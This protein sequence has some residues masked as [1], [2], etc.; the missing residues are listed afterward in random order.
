MTKIQEFVYDPTSGPKLNFQIG[1]YSLKKALSKLV[2][3]VY[4]NTGVF[5]EYQRNVADT[6][7]KKAKLFKQSNFLKGFSGKK[8]DIKAKAADLGFCDDSESV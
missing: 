7:V 3:K 6:V 2:S 8:T 5:V 1:S 4:L